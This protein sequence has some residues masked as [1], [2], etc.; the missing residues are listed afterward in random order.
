M[1]RGVFWIWGGENR[2][3]RPGKNGGY[4]Q[5]GR[6]GGRQGVAPG[7]VELITLLVSSGRV[8]NLGRYSTN[9]F[10]QLICKRNKLKYS[11]YDGIIFKE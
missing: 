8:F 1:V 7:G 4:L 10:D 2:S 6:V 11:D 5:A 3:L 9:T